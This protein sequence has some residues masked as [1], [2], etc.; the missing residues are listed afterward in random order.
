MEIPKEELQYLPTILETLSLHQ[1]LSSK[2]LLTLLHHE[3]R[4][5]STTKSIQ[6]IYEYGHLSL[7]QEIEARLLSETY[8]EEGELWAILATIVKSLGYLQEQGIVYGVLGSDKIFIHDNSVRILDPSATATDPLLIE[9]DRLYSPE[10]LNDLHDIDMFKSDVY[11]AGVI[12]LECGMLENLAKAVEP[13]LSEYFTTFSERYSEDL[14]NILKM[15]LESSPND[16][17]SFSEL[18]HF[19]VNELDMNCTLTDECD[20]CINPAPTDR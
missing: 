1:D 6:A 8:F 4:S 10:I 9:K 19:L 20:G 5:S 14:C 3:V 15:M 11:V 16:R 12:L 2:H 13:D 18:K 17:P 7:R